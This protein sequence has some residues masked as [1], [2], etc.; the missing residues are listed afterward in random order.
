M[1]G[2]Q[3]VKRL[4]GRHAVVT[5]AAVTHMHE[6]AVF[7]REAQKRVFDG[8]S[9]LR[10]ALVIQRNAELRQ[11]HD[12]LRDRFAVAGPPRDIPAVRLLQGGKDCK[13]ALHGCRHVRLVAVFGKRL[14][15]HCRNIHVRLP[16]GQCPAAV[17]QRP[18][19]QLVHIHLPRRLHGGVRILRNF[20]VPA[21]QR[22]QREDRAV[23]ALPGDLFKVGKRF[24]KVK[25]GHIS[26]IFPDS[27]QRQHRARI[28]G[29]FPVTQ[30]TVLLPD[31]RFYIFVIGVKV[32]LRNL[33]TGT[34]QPENQPVSANRT[35]PR[36]GDLRLQIASRFFKLCFRFAAGGQ[37]EQQRKQ[38]QD[39]K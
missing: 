14:Q 25:S 30:H 1:D 24:E 3:R 8:N 26:G 7:L 33:H 21:V 34:R 36:L 19:K 27:R 9:V 37:G 28:F 10:E 4:L 17:R 39:T 2:G 12:H 11:R 22:Q 31:C 16:T 18:R 29:V 23:D 38:E 13:T 20:I 32:F 15:R 35:C 6:R 5:A